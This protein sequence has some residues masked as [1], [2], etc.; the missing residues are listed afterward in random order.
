MG[1]RVTPPV[2]HTE[3]GWEHAGSLAMLPRGGAGSGLTGC[4][5]APGVLPRWLGGHRPG[6]RELRG[7]TPRFAFTLHKATD[8][9]AKPT[10]IEVR[11]SLKRAGTK[12]RR[13]GAAWVVCVFAG[14]TSQTQMSGGTTTQRRAPGLQAPTR[15]QRPSTPVRMKKRDFRLFRVLG[16]GAHVAVFAGPRW[17]QFK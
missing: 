1:Q 6:P 8:A 16:P 7:L 11:P 14:G 12:G 10:V 9:A 13:H 4:S 2:E 15:G 17:G 3:A 5:L